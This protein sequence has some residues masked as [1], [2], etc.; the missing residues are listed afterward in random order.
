MKKNRQAISALVSAAEQ[1]S[2]GKSRSDDRFWKPSV[3]KAGNGYAV[4]R[5][6]PVPD[7]ENV[8]WEQYWDHGFKG[9][10]GQWY[11]E[12]SL[13][14]I[15]QDDPASE[16]NSMLW[17]SVSDDDAPERKQVRRQKRRLHYVSNIMVL[18]DPA[19]PDNDGKVFLYQYG[20]KIFDKLKEAMKPT[21]KY[22]KVEPINPFD[23]W[24]GANFKLRIRQVDGYR[25]Y[26]TSEFEK[27]TTRLDE[28]EALEKIYDK[29]VD[30]REFVDPANYKT[31]D[32]LKER[33][34]RVLQL[35]ATLPAG[36][37]VHDLE[38]SIPEPSMKEASPKLDSE[39]DEDEDSS[40]FDF[41]SKLAAES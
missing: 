6:L 29:L 15:G 37:T 20:K 1:K 24:E 14:S 16:Y 10:T 38:D 36:N 4:I 13:N 34:N 17:N 19:N 26:D 27:E 2:G 21:N 5:F 32:E 33:L 11:I 30:I 28:D 25:N 7:E 3:D 9:P 18:H 41:F 8:P 12:K 22:E 39:T 23:L 31:Y 40:T 35:E